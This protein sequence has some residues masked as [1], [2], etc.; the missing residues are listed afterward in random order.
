MHITEVPNL[1]ERI[2]RYPWRPCPASILECSF[3]HKTNR[4]RR[5]P[6]HTYVL[7]G[8]VHKMCEV[9]IVEA[10]EVAIFDLMLWHVLLAP[11]H[12]RKAKIFRG[13][14]CN[15]FA[16]Y[17]F[18][19]IHV[20]V[21]IECAQRKFCTFSYLIGSAVFCATVQDNLSLSI[22]NLYVTKIINQCSQGCTNCLGTLLTLV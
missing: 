20:S 19:K 13:R 6:L 12:K 18:L 2:L 1:P 21:F 15:L 17:K 3:L 22:N 14:F 10:E 8:T 4:P 5:R 11:N 16:E 9:A 7:Q